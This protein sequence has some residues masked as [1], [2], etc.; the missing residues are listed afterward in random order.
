MKKLLYFSANWCGPCTALSPILQEVAADLEVP[1]E[2][3]DIDQDA[4]EG[5]LAAKYN[6]RAIPT[7]ILFE[8]EK[9][10]DQFIGAKNE[11]AIRNFIKRI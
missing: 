1:L 4:D 7:V 11:L 10:V 3:I 6:I 9:P 8:N 5:L 2:K